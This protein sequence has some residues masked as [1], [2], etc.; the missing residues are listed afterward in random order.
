MARR[1]FGLTDQTSKAEPI[2]GFT[3]RNTVKLDLDNMS[4][5]SAKDWAILVLEKHKLKG[6]VILKSSKKCYHVVFDRYVSW[7]E[8]LSIVGWVAILSK[9]IKVKDYALMQSI[10]MSSTLRVAPKGNKPSPRIVYRYG[11]Q[12]HAIKDFLEY[13]Q[14]IKR[15]S[16]TS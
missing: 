2:L 15:I 5:K 12:N 11:R 6:F 16:C 10:K 13:R 1:E 3:D 4:F 8:N 9:N 14:L 7:D